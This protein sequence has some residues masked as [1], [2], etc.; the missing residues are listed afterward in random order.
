MDKKRYAKKERVLQDQIQLFLQQ[1]ILEVD[2]DCEQNKSGHFM[3]EQFIHV[4]K[5]VNC[6]DLIARGAHP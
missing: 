2:A 5:C 4:E 6:P 1:V 3:A